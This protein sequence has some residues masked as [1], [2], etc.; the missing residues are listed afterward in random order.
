MSEGISH[1]QARSIAESVVEPV[2]GDVRQLERRIAD[3]EE[4]MAKLAQAIAQ[5]NRD[6]GNKLDSIRSTADSGFQSTKQGL[7]QINLTDA[8]GFAAVT[9]G[10]VSVEGAVSNVGQ[11]VSTLDT[12]MQRLTNATIQL[13]LE[14]ALAEVQA[15]LA[16]F[17]AFGHEIDERHMMA[18]TSASVVMTQYA[19]LHTAVREGYDAKLR[20]IGEHIYAIYEGDFV[21]YG[22][23]PLSVDPGDLPQLVQDIERR[24]IGCRSDALD[25]E[26]SEFVKG[27]L[28]PMLG[29]LSALRRD[30]GD[31][32]DIDELE[33]AGGP[34]TIGVPLLAVESK[35]NAREDSD[36]A[37]WAVLLDAEVR[38]HASD[39]PDKATLKL[40]TSK[41]LGSWAAELKNSMPRRIQAGK[42]R[43]LS[44]AEA[45][46]VKRALEDLGREGLVPQALV[47]DLQAYVDQVG[48]TLVTLDGDAR[49]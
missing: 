19:Q 31:R 6:L 3:I 24:L 27:A 21:R 23:L 7:T 29:A 48:I 26:F 8:A 39:G 5:M 16:L 42:E 35:P 4:E 28:E 40:A 37:K 1:S 25:R 45:D 14:R 13:D 43:A 9:A 38:P 18:Q 2:R 30:I 17:K 33:E 10:V 20:T 46:A 49:P 11:R 12:T 41:T 36:E 22:E 44:G 15:P 32:Y 47:G 34:R